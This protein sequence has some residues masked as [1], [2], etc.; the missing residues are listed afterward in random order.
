MS[1]FKINF[2]LFNHIFMLEN[3]LELNI[4]FYLQNDLFLIKYCNSSECI[5]KMMYNTDLLTQTLI[6]NA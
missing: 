3:E 6:N 1:F 5:Y 4:F 2:L